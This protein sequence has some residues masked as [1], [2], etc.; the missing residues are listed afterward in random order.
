VCFHVFFFLYISWRLK[1]LM[2]MVCVFHTELLYVFS[3]SFFSVSWRLKN[4]IPDLENS[5]DMI[6]LLQDQH[7]NPKEMETEFLLCEQVYFKA[8]VPP[9]DKVC[10][11][12]GV[13]IHLNWFFELC[14]IIYHILLESL[15]LKL[16]YQYVIPS[17][18]L[19]YLHS[20]IGPQFWMTLG[21]GASNLTFFWTLIIIL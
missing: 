11:W 5:L 21:G 9:T 2:Y 18:H 6:K 12:L 8:L 1:S 20:K 13:S 17:K 7:D 3:F 10:L 16:K 14:C 4:Q 15:K 19:G